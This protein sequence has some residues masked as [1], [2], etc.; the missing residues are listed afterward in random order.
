MNS[1]RRI[2]LL[3]AG[4]LGATGAWGASGCGSNG[5]STSSGGPDA[6][7]DAEDAQEDVSQI[8]TS[9]GADSQPDTSPIDTGTGADSQPDTSPIDT[10][11]GADSQP[12][13]SPIDT[14]TDSQPDTFV[15]TDAGADAD[16]G[17]PTDASEDTYVYDASAHLAFPPQQA[18]A[19]CAALASCCGTSGDAA[20]FNWAQCVADTLATG[21]FKGS[22]SGVS[23]APYGN[24][25]FNTASAAS[26]LA[27]FGQINCGSDSIPSSA[28]IALYQNCF[29]AY[30]GT[31]GVGAACHASIECQNSEYCTVAADGGTGVCAP[32]QGA[33]G[34]CGTISQDP[35]NI[36][37]QAQCSYRGAAA[38]GLFCQEFVTD[39]ESQP[40]DA[41]AWTCQPQL[42]TGASCLQNQDCQSYQCGAGHV[43]TTSIVAFSASQCAAYTLDAGAGD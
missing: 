20:T 24:I 40:L 38:N 16:G 27:D 43:C 36:I 19:R 1:V 41:A 34:P 32:L 2:V 8:D 25:N 11:T 7:A 39:A 26:C 6:T 14:G 33:G 31:L 23:Y 18:A 35:S 17:A 12:D 13:T 9:T 5:G 21:G 29:G 30:A 28:E 37:P 10:G 3:S 42:P 22:T 4:I 15:A